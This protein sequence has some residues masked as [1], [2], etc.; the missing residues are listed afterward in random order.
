MDDERDEGLLDGF[1]ELPDDTTT[2]SAEDLLEVMGLEATETNVEHMSVLCDAMMLYVNR[3]EV[4]QD[5]WR[6]DGWMGIVYHIRHKSLRVYRL[7]SRHQD[8]DAIPKEDDVRDLINYCV[9][10]LRLLR[11]WQKNKYEG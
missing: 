7:F 8:G 2:W 1:D 4:Y 6:V 11:G 9:F 10:M 3:N 5:L